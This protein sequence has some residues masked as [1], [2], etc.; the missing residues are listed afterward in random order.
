MRPV[1]DEDVVVVTE[2]ELTAPPIPSSPPIDFQKEAYL[3]KLFE[4]EMLPNM[5][6]RGVTCP[7][8]H[9][10]YL[11]CCRYAERKRMNVIYRVCPGCL[12]KIQVSQPAPR[13]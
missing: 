3:N 1:L 5:K 8:C 9:T 10:L 11:Q 7:T 4:E 12:E 13:S 6:H 2:S